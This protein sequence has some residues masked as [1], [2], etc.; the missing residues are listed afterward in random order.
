MVGCKTINAQRWLTKFFDVKYIIPTEANIALEKIRVLQVDSVKRILE[1]HPQDWL[2]QNEI[3]Y[4]LQ[5]WG[6]KEMFCRLDNISKGVAD[7]S[8][9]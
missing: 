1:G 2:T 3:E 9:L 4:I 6:T 5:W 7:G 8:Y